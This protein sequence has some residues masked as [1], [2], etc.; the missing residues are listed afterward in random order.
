MNI[1]NFSL[2]MVDFILSCVSS[3]DLEPHFLQTCFSPNISNSIY[4]IPLIYI[5]CCGAKRDL[6]H[7]CTL[8]TLLKGIVCYKNYCS[9]CNYPVMFALWNKNSEV[10][11]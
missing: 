1:L 7:D 5:V 2:H 6:E 10:A 8:T 11:S 4:H 3:K 9:Q